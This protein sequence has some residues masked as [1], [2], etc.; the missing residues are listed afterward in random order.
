MPM[1]SLLNQG[2]PYH[3]SIPGK[4][5]KVVKIQTEI[6]KN[7]MKTRIDSGQVFEIS[8]MIQQGKKVRKL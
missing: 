7:Q 1:V 6:E 4:G 2:S 3:V 8:L 5:D